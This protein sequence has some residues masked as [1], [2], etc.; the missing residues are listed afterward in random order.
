[1][2]GVISQGLLFSVFPCFPLQEDALHVLDGGIVLCFAG[3]AR[4]LRVVKVGKAL[5][6][7]SDVT[8]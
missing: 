8:L 7:N 4:C 6:A 1:M 3:D 2:T 5:T